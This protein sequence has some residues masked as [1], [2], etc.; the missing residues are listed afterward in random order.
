MSNTQTQTAAEPTEPAAAARAAK[1]ADRVPMRRVIPWASHG[2][3]TAAM[4]LLIGYFTIYA[5]DTLGLNPATVG[6]LLV[7]S[8]VIDAAGALFSGYIVD[9][10]P[11][12]R[13]GKARPFE[14]VL[15]PAWGAAALMFSVP[16]GIGEFAQYVWLF[17]S[18]I[19]LT[20]IFLP[21]YGANQPLYT[22]RVFPKRAHYADV[23]A[24]G[25]IFAVIFAIVLGV[26]MPQAIALAG[27]DPGAWSLVAICVAL[28]AAGIGLIRF[29]MF[30]ESPDAAEISAERV[31]FADIF[32][33]LRTNPYMWA[34]SAMS[35]SAGA[36]SGV[37]AGVYYFRYIVGDIGLQS[38]ASI[39]YVA[40]LPVL[41]IFPMLVRKMSVSHLIAISSLLGATGMM[42]MFFAGSNL[43]LVVLAVIIGGFAFLPFSLLAPILIIDNATYNEYI[44]NRRLESVGGAF[45]SFA[46]TLGAALA[47]GMLGLV[48]TISG[49]DG[50]ADTQTAS[51]TQGIIALN[52]Y[53]PAVFAVI[54]AVIALFY[55]K[56]EHKIKKISAEVMVRRQM[57]LDLEIV[58]GS[59]PSGTEALHIV[60][61]E[62]S[63][64]I[65]FRKNNK[66]DDH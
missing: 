28:P 40:L 31:K 43:A 30:R 56:L 11:E 1:K 22:A 46:N 34:L 44:G 63:R 15:I 38:I 53:I 4:T 14:L 17:V 35:V 3:S 23:N 16:G 6:I 58:P 57:A 52:S 10:A 64:G 19:L 66:K 25:G 13:F 8:K 65:R 7:V 47:A 24:K 21:L 29:F 50:T 48:L 60:R 42:I 33:V 54:T 45:F 49:Y 36:S 2:L 61:S 12:T 41:L 62:S 59:T 27:K 5:T 20:A 51:A 32:H 55:N 18:Y 9:W 39:G 37:S 26:V